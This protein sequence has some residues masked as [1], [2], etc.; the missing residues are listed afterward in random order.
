MPKP[1][2]LYTCE[3]AWA[4][5]PDDG[6]ESFLLQFDTKEEMDLSIQIDRPNLERLL[7]GIA[8]ALRLVR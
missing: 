6:T 2:N 3:R 5:G 1:R 8:E 7:M 4:A